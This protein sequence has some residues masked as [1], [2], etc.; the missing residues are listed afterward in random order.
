MYLPTVAWLILIVASR[1]WG[2]ITRGQSVARRERD[3]LHATAVE[4]PISGDEKAVRPWRP[5]N[6]RG[7]PKKNQVER[8]TPRH[9]TSSIGRSRKSAA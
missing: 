1:N 9:P 6:G 4:E 8:A 2:S 3:K 7:R 5:T